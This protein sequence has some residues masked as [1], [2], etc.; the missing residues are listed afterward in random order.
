MSKEKIVLAYSGGLDTSIIIAWLRENYDFFSLPLFA[1]E[2]SIIAMGGNDQEPDY[3]YTKD[4]TLHVFAL[5]D[6]AKTTI[7]DVDGNLALTA[8]AVNHQGS[9]SIQLTGTYENLKIC[10]RNVTQINNISGGTLEESN[11]GTVIHVEND[12]ITFEILK[13]MA[14]V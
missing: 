14:I 4:L 12:I 8:D 1:R 2:N 13:I 3:D 9:V 6:K 10:M 5:K 7:Y 11:F